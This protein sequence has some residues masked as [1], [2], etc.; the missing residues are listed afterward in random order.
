MGGMIA[1]V[2]EQEIEA[3]TRKISGMVVIGPGIR[4]NVLDVVEHHDYGR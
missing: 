2:E 3:A 4:V 1:I